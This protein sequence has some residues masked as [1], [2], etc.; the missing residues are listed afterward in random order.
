[1]NNVEAGEGGLQNKLVLVIED[2][3][4]LQEVISEILTDAG[5][6]AASALNGETGISLAEEKQPGLIILDLLLP[7]MDGVDV[8]HKLS[9]NEK[10]KRIPVIVLTSRQE[11]STKL[12][13]FMAGAKRYVTKPFEI[14]KLLKEV[15][16]AFKQR[17]LGNHEHGSPDYDR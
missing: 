4:E 14:D 9:V 6:S 10:T 7:D 16:S 13:S 12:S 15:E 17:A 5:Y 11:L 1:M 8:C 3:V 2:S